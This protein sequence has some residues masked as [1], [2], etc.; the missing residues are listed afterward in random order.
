[1]LQPGLSDA[2]SLDKGDLA[3]GAMTVSRGLAML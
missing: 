2:A 3:R 1:M